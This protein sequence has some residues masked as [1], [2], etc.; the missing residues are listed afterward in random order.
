MLDDIFS[1]SSISPRSDA[2]RPQPGATVSRALQSQPT[3]NVLAEHYRYPEELVP[4]SASDR[5]SGAPGF[6]RVGG[7][8]CYGQCTGA[9]PAT[10]PREA[11]ELLPAATE[12]ASAAILPFDVN[13][14]VDD[15]RCERY[16]DRTSRANSTLLA[17]PLVRRLY[18]SL[19]P[20]LPVSVRRHLQQYSLRNW[21]DIPFP[22]WPVDTTVE[23]LLA[24]VLRL[25]M[26]AQNLTRIPFVW[27]WPDGAPGCAMMTHDVETKGGLDFLP[28]LMDVDD[29]YGI[30]AS[31]QL[32]PQ[33]RY[34]TSK[35]LR[36]EI[37]ARGFEVNVQDLTHA[38][39]LFENHGQFLRD[40]SAV[41]AYLTEYGAEG[42]R[43]GSMF[44]NPDWYGSLAAAYDMSIP[45]VAHL[46]AQRGGCCTVFPWFI[47]DVLEL[48][49]TT[50]Q[51]YSLFHILGDYSIE[52]W[53][54]QMQII[55][56]RHGLMSF[57]AHPDYLRSPAAMDVYRALLTE[58][59]ELRRRGRIWMARPFE[60]NQWWRDRS[61]MT[62]QRE[63]GAW[64]IVG[65][66]AERARIAWA[67]IV[68][69]EL[70]YT[71][72]PDLD[73]SQYTAAGASGLCHAAS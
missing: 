58:L 65:P 55:A 45:N 2:G 15:L 42:F 56:A 10:N 32:V 73:G 52:L 48:P 41:N 60:V 24:R 67:Q 25:S 38:G 46:E 33:R 31:F 51:D 37:R 49:L 66:G 53:K 13:R 69:G 1:P 16:A 62:L 36:E 20:A 12:S 26:R 17:S 57:I 6:F 30:K 21:R 72:E 18:Y 28:H 63:G 70:A 8:I 14:V 50:V 35:A 23:Q 61:R 54:K 11:P 4:V 64:R 34:R 59:S 3:R 27:F 22:A 68:E 29:E 9:R 47:G 44:R 5:I 71:I 7:D 19:R 39:N 40:S 43:S